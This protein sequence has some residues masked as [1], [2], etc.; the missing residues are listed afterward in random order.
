MRMSRVTFAAPPRSVNPARQRCR[1]GGRF[2]PTDLRTLAGEPV[3]RVEVALP[4]DV[5]PIRA[6]LGDAG[7]DCLEADLRFAYRY[8][9]DRGVRGG[10]AVEGAYERRR[11][12]GR[13]YRNPV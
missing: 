8:L 3:A 13:V 1:G 12:V 2:L 5:P 9:I 7:I 6:R 11:G 4:A 10:F